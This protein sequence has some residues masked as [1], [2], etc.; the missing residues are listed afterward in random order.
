MH[1]DT[2]HTG[3]TTSD[4]FA[5]GVLGMSKKDKNF[6]LLDFILKKCD[7]ETQA[8]ASIVMYQKYK[9]KVKK[10]TYDEKANQGF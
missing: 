1:A 4:Y 10:F 7:V 6:Y 3:K 5:L 2:T 9:S 8:R